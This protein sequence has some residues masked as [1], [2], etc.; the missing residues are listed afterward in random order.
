MNQTVSMNISLS[1]SNI[2]Q[3]GN[4]SVE[5]S[6]HPMYGSVG[7]NEYNDTNWLIPQLK[8]AA[9]NGM[10][11]PVYENVFKKTYVKTVKTAIEGNAMLTS[12]I[13]NAPAF[14]VPFSD[15]DLSNSFQMIAKTISGR[16]SLEMS[17]Q[18]FFVEYGGWDM[19]NDILTDQAYKL[20]ELD[21]AL[22]QFNAAIEQMGLSNSVTTFSL[23]EFSRTLTSNGNGTDHAW[24]GNTFVMGGAVY[25][26][27]IYGT[28]P[29]LALGSGN[30]QEIGGGSL[31][32][33]TA[34]DQYFAEIALWYGVPASDLVTLFPNIGYF[35][36]VMSNTNP[37][38]FLNLG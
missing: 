17:R 9:I 7:I 6:L 12:V 14:N 22:Y 20:T 8:T 11:N 33:T 5:Y 13:D 32:P 35:Y 26:K 23:S 25:G 31:I 27:K 34:A 29:S 4:N 1:G 24:G 2:F 36:D 3:T 37:L 28:F 19:H 38:G 30:S 15:N 16:N 21:N 10:V 18:I